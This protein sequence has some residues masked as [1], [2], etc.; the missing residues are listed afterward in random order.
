MAII[1]KA[2]FSPLSRLPG[3][4][5]ARFTRL[6]LKRSILTGKRMYYVH[7]L[8]AKYGPVVRIAPDEVAV[9]DPEGVAQIHRIGSGFLKGPWYAGINN[10]PE[11]G[12]FA[13]VN[14]KDH[15]QRRRLFAKAFSN[16]SLRQNWEPTIHEKVKLAVS[17]IKD[18]IQQKKEADML[19]WWTLMATDLM[20]NLS[21]GE[22]FHMLEQGEKNQYVRV[23]ES[24]MVTSGIGYELPWVYSILRRIPLNAVQVIVNSREFIIEYGGKAVDNM[25]QHGSG[26]QNLFGNMMAACEDSDK[27]NFSDLSVRIE[28]ANLLVAGSDTTAN[29]LTYAVWCALKKPDLQRRLVAEVG[30][31]G[32]DYGDADL[33][34]LPLLNAVIDETLRLY[35]AAPGALQRTV[36]RG[37]ATFANHFVPEGTMIETQAYTSHRDPNIWADPLSFDET[38]FLDP[39]K[40][41]KDQ[42]QAFLPFGGGTRVCI[43]IHLARTEL[44]LALAHFFR[45]CPKAK[46]ASTMTDTEMEMENFFLIA[47]RGHRCMITLE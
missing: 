20:A 18:D 27:E 43:G 30:A 14:P 26:S 23:I 28:A 24:A 3:P 8:H 5:H 40:L 31:L 45:E 11:L 10:A 17:K 35:G 37:G 39:S 34:K 9:A 33:E 6:A 19:K 2:F 16:T 32:S 13:M 42:K 25:R 29:T 44:R 41:T 1:S 36:P 38:R 4:W 7:D 47:P 21:F 46:L 15:S 12:I 22:S